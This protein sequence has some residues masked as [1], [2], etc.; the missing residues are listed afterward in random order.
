MSPDARLDF[1]RSKRIN[2][3]EAV[4]CLSKTTEQCVDIVST[5][6]AEG[7][8]A[9]IATRATDEQ[10]AAL[11]KLDPHEQFGSTLIWR[12]RSPS[13]LL[14]TSPSPR[15]ATLSRMPSSA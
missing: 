3:P 12:P 13:C 9:V 5:M 15:D 1:D 11:T 7:N 6:L 14:Y 2:L 4:Y 10:T 8:D